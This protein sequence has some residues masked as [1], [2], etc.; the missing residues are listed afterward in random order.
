MARDENPPFERGNTFWGPGST[1]ADSTSGKQYEGAEYRWEDINYSNS[2]AVKPVRSELP[3]VTRVVRNASSQTALAKQVVKLL[4]TNH[5]Q[6]DGQCIVNGQGPCVVVDEHLPAGGCLQNDL[7]HVV[8]EGP[9]LVTNSS[10]ASTITAGDRVVA[11]TAA[12]TG[13][14]TAGRVITQDTTGAT[15]PLANQIQNAVGVAMSTTSTT[16]ADVL[17]YVRRF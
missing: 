4:A 6:I 1:P 13:A 17:I 10:A 11:A 8:V 7:C 12:T 5:G 14:T 15:T 9:A 16:Q 2:A 3:V